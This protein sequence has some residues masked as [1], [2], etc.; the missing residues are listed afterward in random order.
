MTPRT[1]T[2]FLHMEQAQGVT[3]YL[4]RVGVPYTYELKSEGFRLQ[5]HTVTVDDSR[6]ELLDR[7]VA[8]IKLRQS[9]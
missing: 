3:S 8:I 2:A 9:R 1:Y 5:R 7:I 4:I 6:T